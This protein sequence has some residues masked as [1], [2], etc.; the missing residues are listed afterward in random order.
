KELTVAGLI[1]QAIIRVY[2]RET[3]I[4]LFD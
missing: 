2:E 1:A 4:V 3:V